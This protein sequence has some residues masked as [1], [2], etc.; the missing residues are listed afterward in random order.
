MKKR[1]PELGF[2]FFLSSYF[3]LYC[4]FVHQVIFKAA[5]INS[6]ILYHHNHDRAIL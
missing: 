2:L 5:L 4:I 6:K 1:D 3:A